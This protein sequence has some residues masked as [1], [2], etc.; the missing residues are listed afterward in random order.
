MNGAEYLTTSH[1]GQLDQQRA[2]QLLQSEATFND[3]QSRQALLEI[4]RYP[5]RQLAGLTY[6]RL[7]QEIA[8][9]QCNFNAGLINQ[10]HGEIQNAGAVPLP[11]IAVGF[12]EEIDWPEQL[13]R[14]LNTGTL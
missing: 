8:S 14:I 1:A 9:T 11:L 3:D 4:S 2:E 6:F 12:E 10:L 7:L 5:A 13:N